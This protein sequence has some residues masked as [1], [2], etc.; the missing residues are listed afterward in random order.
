[1]RLSVRSE[2]LDDDVTIVV[3]GIRLTFRCHRARVVAGARVP[4]SRFPGQLV[5]RGDDVCVPSVPR[6]DLRRLDGLDLE[7]L[8]GDVTDRASVVR[9]VAGADVVDHCAAL[10]ELGPLDRT[11][12]EAANV[13]ATRHVL[14]AAAEHGGRSACQLGVGP[15][16]D[17]TGAGGRNLVVTRAA[18]RSLRADQA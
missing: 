1:M 17:R 18:T 16:S 15:R 5:E 2:P 7:T 3:F 14:E 9:A 8:L 11:P 10:V 12:L 13:G 6:S 4:R